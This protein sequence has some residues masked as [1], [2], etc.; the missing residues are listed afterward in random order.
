MNL[1]LSVNGAAGLEAGVTA[2][3]ET[4]GTTGRELRD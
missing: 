4:G 1:S 2:G 3:Q